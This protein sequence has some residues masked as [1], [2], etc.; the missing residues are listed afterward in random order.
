MSG[1]P[2]MVNETNFEDQVVKAAKPVMVDFWA[3]WCAPCRMVAPVVE[4]LA[5]E[6]DGRITVAKLNVD[7]NPKV[8]ARYG[9]RSIPTVIIF[10]GGKPVDQVVGARLEG[11]FRSRLN[12]V[13][14]S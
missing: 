6:F 13:L 3:A 8:A 14:A 12:T 7:E 11:E 10:K 2:L 4:K 1:S 5:K 9:I